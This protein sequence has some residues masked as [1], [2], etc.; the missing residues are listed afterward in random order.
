MTTVRPAVVV[1]PTKT[2]DLGQLRRELTAGLAVVTD[3][4]PLWL[5]TTA[6]DP[7]AGQA[8]RAL[9]DGADLVL[10]YGGDGTQRACAATLA[11]TGVPLALLPAGTGNLLAR[12]LGVPTR[13]DAAVEVSLHGPRRP[14]DVCT[15]GAEPFVVMAG[16][17]FDATMLSGTSDVLK[18]RI[19]WLAYGLAGLHAIGRS[20]AL[21]I[22][23]EMDDGRCV[24]A[25]GVGV[26][27]ANVGTLPG[28]LTLLPGAVE[29]DGLLTVAVL[30]A[31][32]V[33]DWVGLAAR[34]VREAPPSDAQIRCWQTTALRVTVDR[35]V[36]VEVDGDVREA[37]CEQVF[38]VRRRALT[39]CVPD[40]GGQR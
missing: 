11:G 2:R 18:E 10:A 32:H 36:P 21:R 20:P 23:L 12:H 35:P 27:V 26:L 3:R 22:K 29:D 4:A 14:I 5:E 7:G 39:V 15:S 6:N 33:A 28:G 38:A 19:G 40:T 9:A 17:G 34:L 8:R 13:L 24:A 25:D 30:T 31:D 37:R 16:M 1:N